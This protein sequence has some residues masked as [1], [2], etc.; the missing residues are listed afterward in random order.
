M[1][2]IPKLRKDFHSLSVL[3]QE[4]ERKK[5]QGETEALIDEMGQEDEKKAL[6]SVQKYVAELERLQKEEFYKDMEALIK[7]SKDKQKYQRYL[8]FILMRY[9]KEEDISKR[10]TLYSESTDEG[11]VL[12]IEGTEYVSAFKTSGMPQYDIHA[13][14][15]L[16]V[17][18][19]NTVGRLDG[20][21]RATE[22]GILLATEDE[23]KIATKEFDNKNGRNS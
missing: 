9:V 1:S 7:F 12:G 20:N 6:S 23:L 15:V 14:K 16:A 5:V 18:L 2:V 11:V 19:G 17:K 10:Y 13:C 4:R 3:E 22:G 8:I 21:Y